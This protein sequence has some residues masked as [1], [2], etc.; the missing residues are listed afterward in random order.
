M[1]SLALWTSPCW[2]WNGLARLQAGAFTGQHRLARLHGLTCPPLLVGAAPGQHG[3]A[4]THGLCIGFGMDS[5]PHWPRNAIA[6]PEGKS[7]LAQDEQQ[8]IVK[9]LC[10][11]CRHSPRKYKHRNAVA[12]LAHHYPCTVV[13]R[14]VSDNTK[15]YIRAI[16]H[17]WIQTFILLL[18]FCS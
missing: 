4:C 12:M 15:K 8:E 16:E 5:S 17:P 14:I 11:H 3:L 9:T 10:L 13:V 1:D 2:P 6:V 18:H 7:M